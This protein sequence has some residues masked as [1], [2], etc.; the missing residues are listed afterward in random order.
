MTAFLTPAQV[1][2]VHSLMSGQP[3]RDLA[4]LAG[5][6]DR[7]RSQWD[8]ELLYP[9]W[10]QQAAI[11]LISI[12][13]AQAFVDGNK[14]AAWVACDI[15]LQL[16]GYRFGLIGDDEIVRLMTDISTHSADEA[17][18]TA[19]IAARTEPIEGVK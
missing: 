4:G 18:V 14:R 12:S 1:E 9:R 6:V 11:I 10:D 17:T 8:G 3:A 7:T 19:W 16:N 13:Q 15:F 5:A 2:Q